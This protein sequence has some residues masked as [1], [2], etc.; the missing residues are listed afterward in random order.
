LTNQRDQLAEQ[1]RIA[2]AAWEAADQEHLD[3][4]IRNGGSVDAELAIINKRRATDAAVQAKKLET[5]LTQLADHWKD[6]TARMQ[7]ASTGWANSTVD[8]LVNVVKTGKLNFSSLVDQITTDLLK[9]SLQKSVGSGLQVAFDGLTKGFGNLIGGNGK[10]EQANPLPGTLAGA[11]S[12]VLDFL[13]APIEGVTSL[14]NKLTGKG[15]DLTTSLT[16]NAKNLVLG[17]TANTT[18]QSSMVTLGNAALYAA[19]ALASMSGGS[20][21]SGLGGLFGSIGSAA[22]GGSG[23]AAGYGVG[24]NSYGFTMPAASAF[25]DGGIMSQFGPL[26]LRK[27][28]N[29]GVADSPQM[30]IYGEGSMNEAFVP[31]P[32]GKSIPVTM[33]GGSAA[34]ASAPAVTVNVINQTGSQVNAQQSSPRFDGRQMVLDVVLTAVQTPGPFRDGMKQATR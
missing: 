9:I 18:A 16:D 28:A 15:G 7:E 6:T 32:D 17:T 24:S 19:N 26:A 13:K 4:V 12:S 27:Y 22:L 20:S 10:G 34:G 14:F 11:G 8:S 25:A 23:S 2:K 33:T 1:N 29:G 5:P 3:G 21:A 31:L 30:A